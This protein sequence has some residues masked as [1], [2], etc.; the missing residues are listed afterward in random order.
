MLWK[1]EN[2]TIRNNS[3]FFFKKI[4]IIEKKKKMKTNSIEN[5]NVSLMSTLPG[6]VSKEKKKKS[7]FYEILNFCD[8]KKKKNNEKGAIIFSYFDLKEMAKW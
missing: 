8:I 7:F 6:P 4:V 1:K 2:E 5:E 3:I